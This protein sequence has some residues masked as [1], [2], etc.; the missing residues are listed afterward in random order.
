[1]ARANYA[2]VSIERLTAATVAEMA[3][4]YC[5][6]DIVAAFPDGRL[7]LLE[8]IEI[9]FPVMPCPSCHG[10]ARPTCQRCL[11]LGVVGSQTPHGAIAVDERGRARRWHRGVPRRRGEGLYPVHRC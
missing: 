5:G 4:I 1:M 2:L 7:V 9:E 6:A 8:P 3:C 11:G 10:Q